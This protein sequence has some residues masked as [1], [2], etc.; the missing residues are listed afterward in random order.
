MERCNGTFW[1][2]STLRLVGAAVG[3][4]LTTPC[5]GDL[6]YKVWVMMVATPEGENSAK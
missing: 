2:T 4:D 6:I 5:L 3:K 1:N